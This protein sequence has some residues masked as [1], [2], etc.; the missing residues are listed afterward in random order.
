MVAR[1]NQRQY[2][3]DDLVKKLSPKKKKTI[4]GIGSSRANE[5]KPIHLNQGFLRRKIDRRI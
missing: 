5:S 3:I 1:P 2:Y 4:N